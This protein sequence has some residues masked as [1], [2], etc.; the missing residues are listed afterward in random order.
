MAI[1]SDKSHIMNF[2][3]RKLVIAAR[4]ILGLMFLMSGVTGFMAGPEMHNVPE[5]MV[6]TQQALYG[7]GIFQMIKATEIVAGLML[8]F[9]F[10]PAL[11]LLF[12]APICIGIL[13]YTSRVAPGF[14]GS[15]IFVSVFTAYLGYAY[16]DKYKAIFNK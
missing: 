10:F 6:P 13:I 9:G 11:A 5:I 16:W 15:G 8:I 3:N 4:I 2:R 14:I 1:T 7:M 12:V